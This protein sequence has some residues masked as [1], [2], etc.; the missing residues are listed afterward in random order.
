VSE[1]STEERGEG[2]K[3]GRQKFLCVGKSV[4]ELQLLFDREIETVPQGVH[5]NIGLS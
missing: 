1:W 4:V 5:V 2:E 3:E